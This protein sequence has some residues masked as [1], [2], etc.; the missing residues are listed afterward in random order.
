MSKEGLSLLT[1]RRRLLLCGRG[2]IACG[3]HWG[4]SAM[5]EDVCSVITIFSSSEQ[6]IVSLWTQKSPMLAC[7]YEI[8][9]GTIFQKVRGSLTRK[10]THVSMCVY[11][12]RYVCAYVC[13]FVC[14]GVCV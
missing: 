7:F 14:C 9:K 11:I 8:K 13:V 10:P 4:I 3:M 5:S 2:G 12:C 6:D 1:S